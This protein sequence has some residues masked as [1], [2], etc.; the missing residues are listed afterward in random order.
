MEVICFSETSEFLRAVQDLFSL[1][2]NLHQTKMFK[3]CRMSTVDIILFSV[4]VSERRDY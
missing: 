4:A 2:K 3:Q 1:S